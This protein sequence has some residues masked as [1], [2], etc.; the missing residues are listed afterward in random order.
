MFTNWS[1][2][3]D[4]DVALPKNDDDNQFDDEVDNGDIGSPPY[5]PRSSLSES[6]EQSTDNEEG[7]FYEMLVRMCEVIQCY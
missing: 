4:S 3:Y 1:E 2:D 5:S 7:E 6:E